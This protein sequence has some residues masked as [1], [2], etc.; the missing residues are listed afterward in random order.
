MLQIAAALFFLVALIA[1]IA[2]IAGMLHSNFE[3]IVR[4]LR[5]ESMNRQSPAAQPPLRTVNQVFTPV[6]RPVRAPRL[7]AAA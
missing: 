3:A 4:A 7:R 5:G 1:P 6:S 2:I